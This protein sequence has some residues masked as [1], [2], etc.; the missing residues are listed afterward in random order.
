MNK[1]VSKAIEN[2]EKQLK[3]RFL[4]MLIITLGASLL[5][6]MLA[7]KGVILFKLANEQW[8][9]KSSTGYLMPIHPLTSF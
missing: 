7:Y 8:M 9:N 2:E 4:G 3:G 5:G 1:G 6:S